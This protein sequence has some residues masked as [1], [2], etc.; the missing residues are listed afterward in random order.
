M[1]SVAIRAQRAEKNILLPGR[2]SMLRL[3]IQCVYKYIMMSDS[4]R[5]LDSVSIE[6]EKQVMPNVWE[7]VLRD[8]THKRYSIA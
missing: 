7:S 5:E 1:C 8:N 2:I 3:P 6:G 4:F